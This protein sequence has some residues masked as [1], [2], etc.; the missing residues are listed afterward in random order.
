MD[1][2]SDSIS[3]SINR[4]LKWIDHSYL[5][6]DPYDALNSVRFNHFQKWPDL[7]KI[8]I[9]QVNKASPINFRSILAIQ[10]GIDTKGISIFLQGYCKLYDSGIPG[11]LEEDGPVLYSKLIKEKI[12]NNNT[13][14][15]SSH[16]FNYI[17]IKGS[18]LTPDTPDLIGSSNAMKA[19]CQYA[20]HK[21]LDIEHIIDKYY[22]Y[23]VNNF[24]HDHGCFAYGHHIKNKYVPNLD[25]EVISSYR[26]AKRIVENDDINRLCL[27]SLK[28]L[29]EYQNNDGSWYYSYYHDGK[30]RKQLDFH[31]GYI[32]N[33]LIDSIDVYPNMENEIVESIGRAVNSY[34]SIFSSDGRG[35]YRYPRRY[36]TD[37]HNQAQGIITYSKLYD[38]FESRRFN[39]MSKIICK[40]T[41]ENMQDPTGYFYFQ[42]GRL[43]ANKIP[44]M[45][46]SQAWMMLALSEI[47]KSM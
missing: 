40:W 6:W 2:L 39:D 44:Y 20:D 26:Y 22:N 43:L 13:I 38:L 31:Q 24:D 8:A 28:K 9:I 1:Q 27:V 47:L 21:D 30:N 11:P 34:D 41:I 33:G 12:L 5:G 4:L 15:W 18:I 3:R 19:I 10:P 29:I 36:P 23:L 17:N 37:I 16:Y 45:R 32:I 7:C 46:W 14:S 42:R 35:Y 25:A